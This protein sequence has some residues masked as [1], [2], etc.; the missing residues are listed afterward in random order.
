MS[1]KLKT[2]EF[3]ITINNEPVIKI[4]DTSGEMTK[5]DGYSILMRYLLGLPLFDEEQGLE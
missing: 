1:D 4:T 3:C 2:S 5:E